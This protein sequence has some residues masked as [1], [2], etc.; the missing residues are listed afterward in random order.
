MSKKVQ[1]ND[2]HEEREDVHVDLDHKI[3][4]AK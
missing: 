1:K 4:R 3:L 2:D